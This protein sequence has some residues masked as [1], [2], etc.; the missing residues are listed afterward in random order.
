MARAALI[1]WQTRPRPAV[2]PARRSWGATQTVLQASSACSQT[3]AG[4][5]LARTRDGEAPTYPRPP[6]LLHC[7]RLHTGVPRIHRSFS[8]F[9]LTLF[10]CLHGVLKEKQKKT[11]PMGSEDEEGERRDKEREQ[12]VQVCVKLRRSVYA[13]FR[14]GGASCAVLAPGFT[15]FR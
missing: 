15:S 8:P 12:V 10:A 6:P 11:G 4:P 13:R 14:R 3:R 2:R 5:A 1:A 7:A 9:I